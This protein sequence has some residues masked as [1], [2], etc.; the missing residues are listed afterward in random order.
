MG[1]GVGVGVGVGAVAPSFADSGD[2]KRGHKFRVAEEITRFA[3]AGL[4]T[5]LN[6]D[7]IALVT[8]GFSPLSEYALHTAR[9]IGKIRSDFWRFNFGTMTRISLTK[10]RSP[11]FSMGADAGELPEK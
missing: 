2:A 9:P 10:A 11:D 5:P 4:T 1:V 8:N 7:L 3:A 6:P